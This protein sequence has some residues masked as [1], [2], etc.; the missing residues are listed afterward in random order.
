MRTKKTP[1]E[2]AAPRRGK[3][4]K[5][6]QVI[7]MLKRKGGTAETLEEITTAIGSQKH[8]SANVRGSQFPN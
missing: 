1:A 4:N 3:G 5:T 7:A 6:S 8:T 2:R